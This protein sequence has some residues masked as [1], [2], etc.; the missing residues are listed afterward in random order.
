M[1][2]IIDGVVYAY[3]SV[4]ENRK[5]L[6]MAKKYPVLEDTVSTLKLKVQLLENNTVILKDTVSLLTDQ[7]DAERK[8]FDRVMKRQLGKVPF[9]Q[10][11][12]VNFLFGA[13]TT[14][15]AYFMWKFADS[16]EFKVR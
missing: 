4:E 8:I 14:T 12:V 5:L 16:V 2:V 6:K 7:S 1:F 13:L 15:G 9:L 11:P 10:K 3:Q